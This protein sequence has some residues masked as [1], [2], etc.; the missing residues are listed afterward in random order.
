MNTTNLEFKTAAHCEVF[1]NQFAADIQ[2]SIARWDDSHL[3]TIIVYQ[4]QQP[5]IHNQLIALTLL[6][7]LQRR[8]EVK[9][10]EE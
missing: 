8:M 6:R 10:L 5:Q 4:T 9:E 7:E 2:E 3:R 1:A